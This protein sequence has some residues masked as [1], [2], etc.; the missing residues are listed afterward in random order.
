MIFWTIATPGMEQCAEECLRRAL[1]FRGNCAGELCSAHVVR[2]GSKTEA[3]AAKLTHWLELDKPAWFVDADCWM[4][5]KAQIP[6]PPPGLVMGNPDNT[7]GG[8]YSKYEGFDNRMA[9]NTSLVG[10]HGSCWDFREVVADAIR[11]Q[12]EEYGATPRED[13]K[14]LNVA[15]QRSD[16]MVARLSTRWNWCGENPP[17]NTIAIHAAGRPDKFE[18]LTRVSQQYDNAASMDKRLGSA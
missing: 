7:P 12:R 6:V 8:K 2:V 14:F 9:I 17:A 4:V 13:E 10:A 16:L 18:W 3:H 11:M 15:A 1:R 5:S